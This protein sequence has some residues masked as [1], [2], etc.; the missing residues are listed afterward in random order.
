[1]CQEIKVRV[2]FKKSLS[3]GEPIK[4]DI[5]SNSY[6]FVSLLS[7][8]L[9]SHSVTLMLCSP[10][11]KQPIMKWLEGKKLRK[12]YS[13]SKQFCYTFIIIKCSFF[14]FF[15]ASLSK[16]PGPE[17]C[18]ISAFPLPTCHMQ[19]RLVR[20]SLYLVLTCRVFIDKL[21]A[22]R[23]LLSYFLKV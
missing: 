2:W 12:P 18:P 20:F 16:S 21:R 13:E 15:S 10:C 7:L 11:R 23:S 1:M 17:L 22:R 5:W 14:L 19:W 9:P 4:C 8:K 3:A 6:N